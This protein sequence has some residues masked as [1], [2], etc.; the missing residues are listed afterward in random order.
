[1]M[2]DGDFAPGG[3]ETPAHTVSREDAPRITRP[4]RLQIIG[5]GR[6]GL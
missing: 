5:T 3:G 2:T 4:Y 6:T 1:M